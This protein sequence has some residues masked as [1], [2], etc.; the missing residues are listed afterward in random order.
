VSVVSVLLPAVSQQ[1]DGERIML[2]ETQGHLSFCCEG[3]HFAGLRPACCTGFAAL[4][5]CAAKDRIIKSENWGAGA[6]YEWAGEDMH[7]CNDCIMTQGG[8]GGGTRGP[9]MCLHF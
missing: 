9:N 1:V 3:C 8:R 2:A 4:L 6:T 7:C 5:I